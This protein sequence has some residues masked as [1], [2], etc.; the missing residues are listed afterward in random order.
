MVSS[1]APTVWERP[2][3]PVDTVIMTT[4][5]AM[6]VADRTGTAVSRAEAVS[7]AVEDGQDGIDGVARDQQPVRC[8]ASTQAPA[9]STAF[10]SESGS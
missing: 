3:S 2:R 8:Q 6:P 4:E 5:V 1:H 9:S 7:F 10:D